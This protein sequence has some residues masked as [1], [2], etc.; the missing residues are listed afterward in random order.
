MSSPLVEWLRKVKSRPVA[1]LP[2]EPEELATLLRRIDT[3][4]HAAEITAAHYFGL[5][6]RNRVVVRLPL[7]TFALDACG[8]GVRLFWLDHEGRRHGALRL[9]SA[10]VEE[11]AR[12][13]RP[14]SFSAAWSTSR[15]KR[16]TARSG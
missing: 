10:E 2:N 1:A 6:K 8:C 14:P 15:L 12:Q 11:L 13:F 16:S 3:P 7:H 5:I 9:D 4:G